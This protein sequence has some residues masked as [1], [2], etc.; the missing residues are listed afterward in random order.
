MIVF[1]AWLSAAIPSV[2]WP[3]GTGIDTNNYVLG[4]QA[5]GG[6]YRFTTEPMLVE[7]AKRIE[8]MGSNLLKF[9]L[10]HQLKKRGAD[11]PAAGEMR[12]LADLVRR[13]PSVRA[14]FDMP[15]AY[16]LIWV[17]PVSGSK[18]PFR[19][20]L[21]EKERETTYR[22]MR[23]LTEHLLAAYSDTGKTFLLGHWEGDW[24]L[25]PN[26][27]RKRDPS[28]EAIQGM[29]DWL[30]TRQQAVDDAKRE[31]KS[32]GVEVYHYTE[33]NLVRKA[34]RGG[35]SLV[36]DVLPH[37]QV[38]YVS[39]SSYD[40]TSSN[41][42]G[43]R[44]PLHEALDYIAAKL[45]PKEGFEGKRVFVGEYGTPLAAAGTPE[46]QDEISREVCLAAL[47]WG[48]PFVLYWQLYCNE[49]QDGEQRGFWLID[50]RG[51]KQPFYHT[52]SGYYEGIKRF[53]AEYEEMEGRQPNDRKIRERAIELLKQGNAIERP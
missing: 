23:E 34:M 48:C 42:G 52:L 39:Y 3:G 51:R 35:A 45:P 31:A 19:N 28:P 30:N 14:V 2:G 47:E 33:V 37:T 50:D 40:T 17:Y 18:V 15:F 24:H 25:H 26:F 6:D 43:V 38:D 16:Y 20:G 4:T 53:A 10:N 21:S 8:E 41:R 36:N 5:I 7:S 1:A 22:E 27:D 46:K 11:S 12:T 32:S 44:E 29:I 49:Q 9:S 13:D